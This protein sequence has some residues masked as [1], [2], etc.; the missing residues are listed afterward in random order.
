LNNQIRGSV[1]KNLLKKVVG[2]ENSSCGLSLGIDLGDE[3][4]LCLYVVHK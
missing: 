3:L 4:I 2:K 1:A